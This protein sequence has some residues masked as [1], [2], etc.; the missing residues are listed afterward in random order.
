[1]RLMFCPCNGSGVGYYRL[2]QY[3]QLMQLKRGGDVPMFVGCNSLYYANQDV[4][5]V[6]RICTEKSFEGLADFKSR[7]KSRLVIDYDDLL[8]AKEGSLQKYNL[9]LDK[10]DLAENYKC[11]KK[12]LSDV[13]DVVTVSTAALADSLSEFVGRDRIRVLPNYLSIRDWSFDP[14]VSRPTEPVLF[15]AGSASHYSNDKKMY[16]D[17]TPALANWIRKHKSV[18]MG[19]TPPW[20]MEGAREPWVGLDI[21]PKVLYRNTR[22]A[23]FTLAPLSDNVFNRCKSDL[24]YLESCAVGRVCLCADFEGSPYSGAHPL[25]KIRPDMGM[26]ELEEVEHRCI[27]HYGEIL[28]FQYEYLSGRWTDLHMDYFLEAVV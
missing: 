27:E 6:Q 16:G 2:L 13:A 5:V 14:A 4:T 28:Q 18:F 12:Y 23:L 17:F 3:F 22:C 10:T 19:D 7:Y 9:F 15:Y 1:M 21:Y 25:Q 20:F 24:K 26:K 8:W 11:M